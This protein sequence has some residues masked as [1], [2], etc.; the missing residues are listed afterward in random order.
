MA[1]P[2]R[3]EIDRH[4]Y[5]S[6]V[7]AIQSGKHVILTGPPG[8]AKTTLA[9][10]TCKLARGAGWCSG[11]QL[12]TATADWTTYET[13]G[14]LRPSGSDGSLEFQEGLFL[15]AIRAEQWLVIDELNR[16]NFDRAFGQLFTVLAGQSVVLPYEEPK[17]KKPI[18]LI[19]EDGAGEYDAA[20]YAV[21]RVPKAWRIIATMNVF[22]KSLLFEMS[23]ALMR[24]F[25]FIEVPSPSESTF[26]TVWRRALEGLPEEIRERIDRMLMDFLRELHSMKD[27]GPAVF[28]DMA[29]FA[30]MYV[31]EDASASMD[32]LAFQLFYSFLLP[33][34]EGISVPQGRE[35]FSKVRKLV[36]RTHAARLRQ[37]LA[38]VLGVDL[39]TAPINT[40]DDFDADLQ[41][42]DSQNDGSFPGA[43]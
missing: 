28:I 9:E 25:A 37:T 38:G 13:I 15:K 36:G 34:F 12:T 11:Y 42:D 32:E 29:K 40:E 5:L 27:I 8:T 6:I 3:L 24:R 39:P 21:L 30:R 22:D 33:Q 19:M 43:E 4:V 7:S 16:S 14:G 17:S 18:A 23:F 2:H 26:A 1:A 20:A 35:L 31:Q 10:L 41:A